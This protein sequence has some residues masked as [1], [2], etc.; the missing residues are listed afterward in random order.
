ML[1]EMGYNDVLTTVTK[2]KKSCFPPQWNGFLTLLNKSLAE[3]VAGS[4]GTSKGFLTIL[5]GL[6][7]GINLDYGSI[8]WSQ[9]VQTL[10]TS[11]RHS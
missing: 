7:N 10:N 11:T 2:V 8:I 6:Y 1:Y 9:V 4:D 3:R 5:Y